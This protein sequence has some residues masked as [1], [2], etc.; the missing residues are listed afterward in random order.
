MYPAPLRDLLM[1][2]GAAGLFRSKWTDKIQEEWIS[3]LLANRKDISREK[4]ERT[5]K[6][7]E[8]SVPDCLVQGY[9][10]I[11]AALDLPDK[12]D[13]HVL[14]AAI[15]AKASAIITFNLR[16]FPAEKLAPYDIEAQHPDE[17]IHHQFGLNHASVI[18][19]VQRCRARLKNP[20]KSADDY[21]ATLEAQSLPLT[22]G[23]LRDYAAVI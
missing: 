8:A 16:D 11:E 1:E 4:I 13:N 10:T 5:K 21:L 17:F 20:P 7:M 19:A 2:L 18:I 22:V 15:H 23:T 14:A 12:D 3:N 6:L 9:E